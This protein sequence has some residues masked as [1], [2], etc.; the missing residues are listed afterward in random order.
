M[1]IELP[2]IETNLIDT[3]PG[4]TNIALTTRTLDPT[5]IGHGNFVLVDLLSVPPHLDLHGIMKQT[6]GNHRLHIDLKTIIRRLVAHVF[7]LDLGAILF[8]NDDRG[9]FGLEKIEVHA[10][11][12]QRIFGTPSADAHIGRIRRANDGHIRYER[13]IFFAFVTPFVLEIGQQVLQRDFGVGLENIGLTI[14]RF[15]DELPTILDHRLDF[16]DE[17]IDVLKNLA[18]EPFGIG[19]DLRLEGRERILPFRRLISELQNGFVNRS[20]HP[21]DG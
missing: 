1:L 21:S 12:N 8:Q 15:L 16:S 11:K 19:G 17:P 14:R 4:L 20:A 18:R 2:A 9:G 3:R 6:R 10:R 13:P 7:R 5:T